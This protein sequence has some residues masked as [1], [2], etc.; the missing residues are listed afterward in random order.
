MVLV[1]KAG[2]I[3]AQLSKEEWIGIGKKYFKLA[4]QT[5]WWKN[6]LKE[7]E[8]KKGKEK[9]EKKEQ[10]SASVAK[11]NLKG[12]TFDISREAWAEM[13]KKAGFW[14]EYWHMNGEN[15]PLEEAAGETKVPP[16]N[17]KGQVEKGEGKRRSAWP[18]KIVE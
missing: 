13:G 14:E 18:V 7:Q 3:Y 16:S 11:L 2:K 6:F 5:E 17:S 1:K 15:T 12:G 4:E 8:E 10:K 9:E